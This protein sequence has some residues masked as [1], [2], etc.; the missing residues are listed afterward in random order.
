METKE[1]IDSLSS[2]YGWTVREK[3]RVSDLIRQDGIDLIKSIRANNF[4]ASS[5]MTDDFI[6]D[7]YITDKKIL[8][9]S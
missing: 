4:P 8:H 2:H 7:M 1:T 9:N 6:Y 5:D 3:Q